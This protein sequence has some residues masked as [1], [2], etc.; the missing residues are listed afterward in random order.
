MLDHYKIAFAIVM[1]YTLFAF[2][3]G[4][5]AYVF[6]TF[7]FPVVLTYASFLQRCAV[8]Y[9]LIVF[10]FP[11]AYDV[12]PFFFEGFALFLSFRLVCAIASPCN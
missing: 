12:A 6:V 5:V 11:V 3:M 2:M 9:M 10:V 7:I 4:T 1:T 8:T